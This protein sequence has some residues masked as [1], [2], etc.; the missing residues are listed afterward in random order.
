M[1]GAWVAMRQQYD[2][3]IVNG[4]KMNEIMLEMLLEER[5]LGSKNF[6]AWEN[7]VLGRVFVAR[8]NDLPGR[9]KARCQAASDAAYSA[10]FASED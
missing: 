10:A 3:K 1:K 7:E 9:Y 5:A 6:T 4:L 8:K 2:Q